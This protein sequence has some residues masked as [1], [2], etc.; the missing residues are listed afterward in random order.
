MSFASPVALWALVLLPLAAAGYVLLER[1]RIREASR[2]V[3]PGLLPNVVDH[4][5]GWRRH[6]PAAILLLA[7][8][9]WLLASAGRKK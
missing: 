1:R 4:V 6:L 9:I 8:A 5:P 3:A 7:G 2:F